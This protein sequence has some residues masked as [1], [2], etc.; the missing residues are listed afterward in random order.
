MN[1]TE[2]LHCG[3]AF[4]RHYWLSNQ[5]GHGRPTSVTP[6]RSS[7]HGEVVTAARS[8]VDA[9]GWKAATDMDPMSFLWPTIDFRSRIASMAVMCCR[10]RQTNRTLSDDWSRCKCGYNW[11]RCLS[12]AWRRLSWP[13]PWPCLRFRRRFRRRSTPPRW[14][15]ERPNSPISTLE[16]SCSLPSSLRPVLHYCVPLPTPSG[17]KTQHATPSVDKIYS[18]R[19]KTLY[20]VL[21]SYPLLNVTSIL[22]HCGFKVALL[23]LPL[24]HQVHRTSMSHCDSWASSC[25]QSQL[26]KG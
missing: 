7:G 2:C 8:E 18:K 24:K 23:R 22:P 1:T 20:F 12:N 17:G 25:A 26:L 14:G 3:T 15:P 10:Q 5:S 6:L 21:W 9:G 19:L 11:R 13:C 4:T 16:V